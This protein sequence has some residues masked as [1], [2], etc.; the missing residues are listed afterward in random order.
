M[1]PVRFTKRYW[2]VNTNWFASTRGV[3]AYRA[4]RTAWHYHETNGT[5][6]SLISGNVHD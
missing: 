6:Q 3:F 4:R 2:N 5:R 1:D